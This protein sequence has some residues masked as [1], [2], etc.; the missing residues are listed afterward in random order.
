[1]FLDKEVNSVVLQE[2][3]LLVMGNKEI[4]EYSLNTCQA[5]NRYRTEHSHFSVAQNKLISVHNG[6]IY[7]HRS[8]EIGGKTEKEESENVSGNRKSEQSEMEGEVVGRIEGE[9]QNRRIHIADEWVY[10]YTVENGSMHITKS[11]I[12]ADPKTKKEKLPLIEIPEHFVWKNDSVY[13]V[14]ESTLYEHNASTGEAISHVTLPR[15]K[16]C[17]LEVTDHYAVVAVDNILLIINLS[18]K[19]VQKVTWHSSEIRK[20]LQLTDDLIISQSSRGIILLTDCNSHSNTYITT[21]HEIIREKFRGEKA[22]KSAL[23]VSPLG[24]LAIHCESYIRIVNIPS[25]TVQTIYLLKAAKSAVEVQKKSL[26]KEEFVPTFD[27]P[28]KNRKI[29]QVFS[30]GMY[31]PESTM[32][33][34]GNALVFVSGGEAYRIFQEIPEI[35]SAFYSNGYILVSTVETEELEILREKVVEQKEKLIYRLYKILPNA[36]EIVAEAEM[37]EIESAKEIKRVEVD[38]TSVRITI[39]QNGATLT[40][41][42]DHSLSSIQ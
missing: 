37:Q 27:E 35:K 21:D 12:S 28:E 11:R 13:F 7:L 17:A 31:L 9:I 36:L 24:Y 4:E 10:V 33:C 15:I 3:S 14:K 32:Y 29:M 8:R 39:E 18:S 40:S 41:E 34:V 42:Y 1:M 6:S 23:Y 5:T 2:N 19:I 25:K 22:K 20:I 26:E 30:R 16:V 38:S